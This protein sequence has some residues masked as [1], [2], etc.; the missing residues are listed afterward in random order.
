MDLLITLRMESRKKKDF[1]TADK[2]RDSLA[3][4]GVVLEDRKDGT[5]W[6][7]Q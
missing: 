6:R 2:I 3:A 4:I 7:V 1:A 5:V